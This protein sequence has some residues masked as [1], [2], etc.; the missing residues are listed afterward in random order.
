MGENPQKG[1]R[2]FLSR[3]CTQPSADAHAPKYN[4]RALLFS[5]SLRVSI[6]FVFRPLHSSTVVSCVFFQ[7]QCSSMDQEQEVA[8]ADVIIP[9]HG[10][11]SLRETRAKTTISLKKKP[12]LTS[13]RLSSLKDSMRKI[14]SMMKRF[15]EAMTP[16]SL[17]QLEPDR[18]TGRPFDEAATH[19]GLAEYANLHLPEDESLVNQDNVVPL[20][21]KEL[22]SLSFEGGGRRP[23]CSPCSG[24]VC[25]GLYHSEN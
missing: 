9:D 11:L 10:E 4:L 20:D 7:R 23:R 6:K 2:N 16:Q 25:Y 19:V 1:K 8:G 5:S 17:D 21:A 22:P 18:E 3:R 15:M 13:E 14:G 24:Q 12:S